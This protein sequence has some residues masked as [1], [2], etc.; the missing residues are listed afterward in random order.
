MTHWPIKTDVSISAVIGITTRLRPVLRASSTTS[1]VLPE[2][3]SPHTITIRLLCAATEIF[4]SC[5]SDAGVS[6]N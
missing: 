2:Q 6:T 1:D 5:L 4:W 3:S